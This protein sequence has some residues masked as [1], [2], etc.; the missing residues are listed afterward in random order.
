MDRQLNNNQIQKSQNSPQ[1]QIRN[2][3]QSRSLSINYKLTQLTV[4]EI[5]SKAGYLEK[6]YEKK[7]PTFK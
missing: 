4:L 7:L 5:L 3:R 1:I 2:Y 6:I